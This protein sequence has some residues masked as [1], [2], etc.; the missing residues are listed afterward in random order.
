MTN[1]PLIQLKPVGRMWRVYVD[2]VCRAFCANFLH[3]Q[4]RADQLLA[5][6][7]AQA[8]RKQGGEA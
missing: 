8:Q 3:A 1:Q 4:Y 5:E 7:E 6:L 2:G